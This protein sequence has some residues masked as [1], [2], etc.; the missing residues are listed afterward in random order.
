LHDAAR[1][2]LAEVHQVRAQA[3]LDPLQGPDSAH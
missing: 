2:I 3:G 1:G